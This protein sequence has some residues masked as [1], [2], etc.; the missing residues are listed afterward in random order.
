MKTIAL[1]KTVVYVGSIVDYR[2]TFPNHT[3]TVVTKADES[4]TSLAKVLLNMNELKS[5]MGMVP[6]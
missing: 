3:K 1:R 2:R 4:I 5:K 6:T